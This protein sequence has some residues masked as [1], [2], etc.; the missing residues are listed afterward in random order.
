MIDPA[1]MWTW[2]LVCRREEIR[3]VV[4]AAAEAITRDVGELGLRDPG[5]WLPDGDPHKVSASQVLINQG[6][7]NFGYDVFGNETNSTGIDGR[8]APTS[9]ATPPT[10]P[11]PPPPAPSPRSG[12]SS[13][14]ISNASWPCVPIS[15][16]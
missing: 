15:S 1:V 13:I 4:L 3:P 12:L 11:I 6:V 8:S 10:A 14:P 9:S 5:T 7:N 2:S 16:W